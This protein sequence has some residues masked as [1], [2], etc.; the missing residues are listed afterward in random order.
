LAG[1]AGSG[2]GYVVKNVLLFDG[3]T[4]NVDDLKEKI[5]KLAKM[6]PNCKFATKFRAM[7]DYELKDLNFKNGQ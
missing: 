1:G 3:K 7:Y 2:K 6:K 5:V 4:F